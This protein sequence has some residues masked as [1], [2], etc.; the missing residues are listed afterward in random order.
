MAL[1]LDAETIVSEE[2]RQ[3]PPPAPDIAQLAP[4]FPQLEIL[5]CLG[6]GGMGVVYK[7]RQKT[8]N[9]MVALKLLAPEREAD[10]AFAERFAREAQALAALSHP[11]IVTVH[12]FGQ[13]GGYFYL[14]MEFV[15]G[16]NLRQA[17]KAGRFT[18]PQALAMVPPICEALQ[19]AHDRGV[20]HRDIKPE[21]L[22]L[23]KEG[24]LK[25]ADF[26]IAKMIGSP[27]GTNAPA[28]PNQ[29]FTMA[30][31]T[32]QY[33]A[34]EQAENPAQ[35]DHRA[36]IYSLGVVLYELL[37]GERPKDKI[38]PP[39]KR[40]QIDVRLDEVV[41]RA[42]ERDPDLRY[43]SAAEFRTQVETIAQDPPRAA[44]KPAQGLQRVFENILPRHWFEAMRIQSQDWH[45]VCPCGH[46]T[47][48]WDAGGIRFAAAGKPRRMM[49]CPACHRFRMCTAVWRG[50]GTQA[51]AVAEDKVASVRPNW[52]DVAALSLTM[53][54]FILILGVLLLDSLPIAGATVVLLP[55][56]VALPGAFFFAMYWLN[57]WDWRTEVDA[58]EKYCKAFAL[59]AW[60]LALPLVGF[61][62]FFLQSAATSTGSWNPA[63]AEAFAV[64]LT[65]LGALPIPW[66]GWRLWSLPRR[67]R[68]PRTS[69]T[70][71]QLG[72]LIAAVVMLL[73]MVGLAVPASV[74][75]YQRTR[76]ATQ[77]WSEARRAEAEALRQR[78]EKVS[79]A[80]QP[81]APPPTSPP[82]R[83]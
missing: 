51:P 35:V 77:E 66:A 83:P 2:T 20:V 47:S 6:R 7:A 38:E 58:A 18:P 5:D 31:G 13:A 44:P 81:T 42:L 55:A 63:P 52:L 78:W 43:A 71:W 76:A 23:D 15:D 48:V 54:Y 39:S 70:W 9:R 11:N 69:H 10:P 72:C 32:P 3:K 59:L 34:P 27:S 24:R 53:F 68:E 21:N 46:E 28:T 36:D 40:V 25:I 82:R 33:M 50:P 49:F 56:A 17:M 8:L 12:D 41:L 29:S 74:M 62:L 14:L 45:M 61:S 57:R 67:M 30:A 37:T 19:Y 26:G 65:W 73:L 4:H 80:T 22:L 64:P 75:L 79:P 60:L 1:N 16:V